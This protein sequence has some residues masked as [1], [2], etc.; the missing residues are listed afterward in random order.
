MTID[1]EAYNRSR[2]SFSLL[3]WRIA[4]LLQERKIKIKDLSG[5]IL[6]R[7]LYSIFP[8]GN[9]ILHYLCDSPDELIS[10]LDFCHPEGKILHHIPFLPN[11]EGKTPLHVCVEK[12]AY[13]SIDTFLKYLKLYPA[14]HHSKAIKDIYAELVD[15]RVPELDDYFESR[16]QQNVILEQIT[17]GNIRDETNGFTTSS[18][19]LNE[20]KFNEEV[21]E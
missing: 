4:E 1:F 19:W 2:H 16:I 15:L 9:T 3:Q 20:D 14:D 7:L 10:L 12:S 8:G 18:P 11:F 17:K 5:D 6:Q 13:K 21:L